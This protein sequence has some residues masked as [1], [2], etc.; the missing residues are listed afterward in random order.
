MPLRIDSVVKRFGDLTA[1]DGVS[2]DVPERVCLGLLGPNGAGKSTLIRSI[3]GRVL[4]DSG[5]IRVFGQLAGSAAARAELGWVPQD[6]ALYPLLTCREN[7]EAFGRYQDLRGK[8]L[9]DGIA[10]CL[11]WAAL[12]DRAGATVK[13]LSG[14]MRRRLNMA[15]GL[16]HRPLIVLLDE[17]TV[18]VDPQ[19]R[20]RI[21]EMVEELRTQGA[22]II[23]TT[24]YMEEAER[25][26]D[27]IAIMDHGKVIAH[28]SKEELVE[29]SFGRRSDVL[30]RF[31]STVENGAAWAATRGGTCE[32]G[33]AHFSVAQPTEIAGLLD[34]AGRDGMEV[35]DVV[36]RRPNLESVFLQLTGR[37]LR[38]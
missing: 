16:V 13:T 31:A 17:P 1:V 30:M 33:V 36:L 29:R 23:Y 7:L 8:P 14:G 5:S 37:D 25:L 10:W 22:T 24:H 11:E 27:T 21:F 20:N 9:R 18:G 32:E 2:L 3:A 28:G 15:A 38:Q 4:P 12:A 34:A 35:I 19:S 26:C 6:L